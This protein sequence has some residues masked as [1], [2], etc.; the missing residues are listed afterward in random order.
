MNTP[1]VSCIIPAYNC[2]RYLP[3]TL[4]FLSKQ[5]WKNREVIIIDDCSQEDLEPLVKRLGLELGLTYTYYRLK[6][7]GGPSIA[8]KTGMQF[9][10][11]QYIQFLD[12]DDILLPDKIEKNVIMLEEHPHWLM[13][14]STTEY[15]DSEGNPTGRI[16]GLSN[17]NIDSI[18]PLSLQRAL[19]QTTSCLW[20]KANLKESHWKNLRGPEDILFDWLHGLEMPS[21][22]WTP[23]ES[24]QVYKVLHEDSLSSSIG[25]DLRYQIEIFRTYEIF[26]EAL[27][28]SSYLHKNE[29]L[30]IMAKKYLEKVFT[31]LR[32]RDVGHA[33]KS[34][35]KAVKI[36]ASFPSIVERAVLFFDRF[37]LGNWIW[38]LLRKWYWIKKKL[39]L[40]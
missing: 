40:R 9:A 26:L 20:R 2:S 24:S 4:S 15:A 12:S 23:S 38:I 16:L 19:W 29:I 14:Y 32:L 33:R 22:G 36:N 35:E 34:L 39:T 27:Q 37:Q 25:F 13:T 5:T 18:L 17:Q 30:E 10:N 3:N 6:T 1:L 28:Y 21:I 7:N 11:G 31:F 8:R